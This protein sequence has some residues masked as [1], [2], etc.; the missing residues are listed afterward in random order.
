[1]NVSSQYLVK[2]SGQVFTPPAIVTLMLDKV[3]Y[4]GQFDKHIIDNS[5]G[6][7]AFLV[8]IITRYITQAQADNKSNEEIA[9]GLSLYVHGIE[10]DPVAHANCLYNL[11]TAAAAMGVR[12]VSWD[13][14]LSDAL[15]VDDYDGKMD[16]VVGNPPYV[17]VHNLSEDYHAAKRFSFC[18]SGMT[19]LYLV[20]YEL[21]LRM[22]SRQG[23]MCYIAPSSWL[24]SKAGAPM[25]QYISNSRRLT[26]L[27]D[28]GHTRL[29][30]GVSTYALIAVFDNGPRNNNIKYYKSDGGKPW[31]VE[32]LGYGE[33]EIEGS[34]YLG[35]HGTL[36][37]L[38]EILSARVNRLVTVKNGF[39]TLADRVF[40]HD[41]D[42]DALTIPV[43]KASTGKWQRCF[44]PYDKDGCPLSRETIFAYTEIAKY[45]NRNRST[46]VKRALDNVDDEWF[47]FGRTQAL[48]DVG[49]SKLSVNTIIKDVASIKVTEVPVGAGLY[50][51]LY[52][53]TA[54]PQETIKALICSED[55]VAY[56]AM[57]KNYKSGGYYTFSSRDLERYLNYKISQI[58]NHATINPNG[59]RDL[60]TDYH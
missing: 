38:R 37:Q 45:L 1:M 40:I 41:I 17:R 47:L 33:I 15:V 44:Y 7:G 11:E 4:A 43:L 52:I 6:D 53:L 32:A 19:D 2:H 14:R 55:F 23:K 49:K 42:F 50:S 5:C 54:L 34:F 20:F 16:F 59:Q 36:R 48:K 39:A 26:A 51:G 46:L 18:S 9:T 56:V 30:E 22:M 21:G 58:P 28:F 8:D 24:T 60:F 12:N 29:F 13:I 57:L 10:K 35:T 25:R 31:I 27:I 3:G